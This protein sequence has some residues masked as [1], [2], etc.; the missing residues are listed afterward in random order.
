MLPEG[1]S[2][3]HVMMAAEFLSHMVAQRSS[4]GYEK[5]LELIV[6]GAMTYYRPREDEFP[7]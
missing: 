3:K 7:T 4:A 1:A 2:F 5:A 6:Q